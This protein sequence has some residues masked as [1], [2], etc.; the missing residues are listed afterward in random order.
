MANIS[1]VVK[2]IQD[3]MRKDAGINGDAQRLEQLAWMFF[4]KMFNDREAEL[5]LRDDKY[6]SPLMKKG[7]PGTRYSSSSTPNSYP[8]LKR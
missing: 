1:G 5:E 8:N 4:L 6:K 3:I 2:S 7:L